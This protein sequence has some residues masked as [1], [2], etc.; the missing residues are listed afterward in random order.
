MSTPKRAVRVANCSGA[1]GD[2]GVHMFNQAKYGPVDVITGDY[3]AELN[4]ASQA[5][6]YHAGKVPGYIP[7]AWDGI[8][9]T[10]ELANEKRIKI[11]LNGGG[12]NP[13][14]LAERVHEAVKE[15]NLNLKV[16]YVEGDNLM[17]KV[18]EILSSIKA[19]TYSHL[20]KANAEVQLADNSLSFLDDPKNMPI[21][22][23]NAYLGYRAIKKGLDEGADIVICGR[24]ADASPVIAAAAWWHQWDTT[25][26]DELA[27]ALIAGHLIECST[28]VTGANFAGAYKYQ[29]KDLMNLGLPIVEIL[30]NG[31]CVMT[32][33]EA[34]NGIMT[35]DT[36]KCQLLYELQGN[37]YLNS[38]VKADINHIK[39][40]QEAKER[41]HVSGVKGYPPPPTTKLAVFYRGGYQCEMVMNATGYATDWKYDYQEA[42]IRSKLEEWDLTKHFDIL[43]FQRVGRPMENPDCQLASTT[44]LRIFAQAKDA[45]TLGK[46]LQAWMYNGMAHFAGMHC[47]MDMRTAIPKSYLGFYPATIPQSELEE[48]VNILT[49]DGK[50]Q[51]IVVG[52]PQKTEPLQARE[53]YEP[54][55]AAA[56][57][58]FGPTVMRPIGDIVLGRSGDKG[59]NINCG[60]YVQTAAQWEWLRSFLTRNKIKELMGK[61][62]NDRYYV[63]R[64]EMANI[65]AVHY[66]IYGPL[67]RGVSSSKLLDSL[68]KGFAE[69]IRAVHVPIPTKFLDE[70]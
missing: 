37:I 59:G 42:Q 61:D 47:S 10:M 12:L 7:T 1:A 40:V 44:Y 62:W 21:V 57:D 36:V 6:E 22:C 24:V 19:G 16:A 20:D 11:V 31:E 70:A 14:G 39:V 33:H 50:T 64:V 27:G 52:P 43:D 25:N 28:Y 2:P 49:T 69:F 58:S 3:L 8:Q 26:Y 53:N 23:A 5:E 30:A 56:L 15:K 34:L 13:R 60:L 67:G 65:F 48:S 29:V 17:H 55:N 68:G 51:V 46:L 63:E 4:L 38:D 41:V 66:V 18:D 54:T 9:Q 45:G 32:K 35:A